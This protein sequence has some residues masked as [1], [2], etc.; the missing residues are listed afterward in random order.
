MYQKLAV[1]RTPYTQVL[2][3]NNKNA[4]AD[5]QCSESTGRAPRAT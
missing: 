4:W 5:V 2:Y 3:L 1:G